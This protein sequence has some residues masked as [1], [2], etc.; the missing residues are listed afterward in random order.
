MTPSR[1]RMPVLLVV[2]DGVHDLE[3]AVQIAE[4]LRALVVL[5]VDLPSGMVS[6][7]MSIGVTLSSDG[8]SLDDVVARADAAMY[9]A[10]NSGRDQVFAIA[11]R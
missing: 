10:K 4:N 3:D 2:L 6:T 8:E 7:T 5:P 9:R 1:R 11:S